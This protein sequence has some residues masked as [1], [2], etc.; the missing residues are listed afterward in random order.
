MIVLLDDTRFLGNH[1]ATFIH[2]IAC[3]I[4]NRT[5]VANLGLGRYA[6]F[7]NSTRGDLFA[8][9]P[10]HRSL[11]QPNSARR[12]RVARWT[13]RL[14]LVLEQGKLRRLGQSYV[15]TIQSGTDTTVGKTDEQKR[16]LIVDLDSADFRAKLSEIPVLILRGPLFRAQTSI[17]RH[18]K[19]VRDFLRPSGEHQARIDALVQSLRSDCDVLVG[20]HIRRSDYASFMGGKFLYGWEQYACQM[21]RVRELFAGKK[22]GFLIQSDVP[23]TPG[24]F[25]EFRFRLAQGMLLEDIFALAECDYLLGPPS[26][27]L[28]LASFYGEVPHYKIM[29]P[30][31][32]P[33]LDD[34]VI[35]RG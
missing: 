18:Y 7:F 25:E 10:A 29:H 34:F 26:T 13:A 14:A 21:G 5:T 28:S 3:G 16:N 35:N 32:V 31:Q 30:D 2:V 9:Y 24:A 20:V 11:V 6:S 4:A 17:R 19:E 33:T 22:C 15:R 23:V 8:R 27:L 12:A 1:L